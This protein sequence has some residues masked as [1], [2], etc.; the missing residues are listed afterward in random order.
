MK[1]EYEE[2]ESVD[3]FLMVA[4]N[5]FSFGMRQIT[6]LFL[7]GDY[8]VTYSPIL[9][10]EDGDSMWVIS[11]VK[12]TLPT[13]LIEFDSETKKVEKIQKAVNPEKSHFLVIKPKSSTILEKAFE[14]FRKL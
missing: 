5:G 1:F 7:H 4:A 9:S 3:D 14:N 6:T 10:G 13:G 2:F 11:L 12:G 8:V